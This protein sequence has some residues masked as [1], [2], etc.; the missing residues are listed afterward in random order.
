MTLKRVWMPSPCY[1][2][3]GGSGVRLI[4][5]H[6]AEG[7]RT[8]ES[9]GNFFKNS[10]NS[11][12]SHTGADNQKGKIGEYVTRGNKAWTAANYN[13]VA[14]QL[15]LC[16]F[17]AWSRDT[18]M[19]QNHNMLSNCAEWIKEEA[20]KFGIPITRLNSSQAQ[21]TGRGVCQHVDLG[22]G[23]GNHH[24]CGTGFPMDYVINLAKGQSVVT[25]PKPDTTPERYNTMFYLQFN[26]DGDA[27][28]AVPNYFSD[29]KARIRLFTG[30]KS[31]VRINFPGSPTAK[32]TVGDG[33]TD[34]AAIP[35]GCRGVI[36]RRDSGKDPMSG[37][38]SK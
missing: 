24:D 37:C 10:A 21:G 29:G 27:F 4:V 12:S 2:S 13:P 11:V 1:S 31:D 14:V 7:A 15:E 3:R 32:V 26:T 20:A 28:V 8:I 22:S 9:L 23:G 18:W 6:T 5:L 30:T 25:P 35:D 17:A 16:G 38:F 36:V 34:G 19:N 33:K